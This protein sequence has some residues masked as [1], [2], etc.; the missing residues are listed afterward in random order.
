MY[1]IE[2]Y[3]LRQVWLLK[4]IM[5]K[6]TTTSICIIIPTYNEKEN[7]CTFIP[8]IQET[9]AS[10]KL[11]ISIL[12][13]DDN[14]SDGTYELV[15]EL[16]KFSKNIS[17]IRRPR[18]LGLGS[19]YKDGFRYAL[20]KLDS[21]VVI[22]MDADGSHDPKYIPALIAKITE[23]YDIVVCCRNIS[24]GAISGWG[25]KRRLISYS[26][27]KIAR[28]LVGIKVSD[29]TT[30]YR[31]YARQALQKINPDQIFSTGFNFQVEALF[32]AQKSRLK[33]AE[34]PFT[35]IDR[36]KGKSKLTIK[37]IISFLTT[38]LT[39]FKTRARDKLKHI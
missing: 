30:G 7:L 15:E 37:E 8:K 4:I 33:I 22:Q 13:V 11:N 32:Y 34:V 14:S 1:N 39:L 17:V 27:N 36:T 25:L 5:K 28:W 10:H 23:G 6:E 2:P 29:T 20:E 19:A 31:A 9:A 21:Q 3:K 26:A 12:I 38:C 35:F 24:G 18:K 16:S